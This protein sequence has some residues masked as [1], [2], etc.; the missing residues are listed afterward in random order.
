MILNIGTSEI[1]MIIL[2]FCL[3]INADELPKIALKISNLFFVFKKHTSDLHFLVINNIKEL[4]KQNDEILDS[5]IK[6]KKELTKDFKDFD[7][8]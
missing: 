6:E 4:K 8:C 7:E 3:F 5:I 1:I 2:I